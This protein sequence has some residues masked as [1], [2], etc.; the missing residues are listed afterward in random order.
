MKN[1]FLLSGQDLI[2][3]L[4]MTCKERNSIKVLVETVFLFS[5][6]FIS[7]F[8][9][10][11]NEWP[12]FHGFERTNKSSETGL[13]KQWPAEGVKLLWTIEGLAEG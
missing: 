7:G 11:S 1:S 8:G 6:T 3:K 10:N 12:C 2:R 9:Q 4:T 5:A 13:M